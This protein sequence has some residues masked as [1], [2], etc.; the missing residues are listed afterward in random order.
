[1][2]HVFPY[3]SFF[4]GIAEQVG[5]MKSGHQ[6]N[7]MEI[8]KRSSQSGDRFPGVQKGLCGKGSQRT[9]NSGTNDFELT[10]QKRETGLDFVGFRIAVAGGMTLDYI[11]QIHI[12][13]PEMHGLND[14]VEQLPGFP[15]KRLSESIFIIAGAFSHEH[16]FRPGVPRTKDNMFSPGCQFAAP[17]VT[18]F[19]P[20]IIKR[21]I[22]CR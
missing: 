18:K 7:V 1:L 6:W 22:S 14:F 15:D 16:Q 17:A 11:A 5:G 8:V 13:T 12:L 21:F 4:V 10:Q 2:L 9:D 3:L 20:D 19:G